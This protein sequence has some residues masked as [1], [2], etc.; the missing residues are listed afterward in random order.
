MPTAAATK[1]RARGSKVNKRL[2]I[3]KLLFLPI[4]V[5]AMMSQHVYHDDGF[6]DTTWEVLSF[7]FLL[8]ASFGRVWTSAFISG[9]KNRELVVDGPYSVTRNPLYF[10]SFLGYIGAGLAFE[11]LTVALA[12][13][14][15]FLLTHWPTILYEER[16]LRDLFGEKFD[17]YAASVP[18]FWPRFGLMKMP[19][20]VVFLPEMYNRAVLDC[21][22]IMSVF[23]LAHFIEYAQSAGWIPVYVHNVW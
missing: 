7:L 11:K 2:L 13:A 18:R 6:W 23:I 22:L 19:E 9:K 8:V 10:F 16:K 4:I 14:I 15:L 12:F 17:K 20:S 3:P 1:T 5:F 21:A